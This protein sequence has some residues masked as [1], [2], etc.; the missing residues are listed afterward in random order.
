MA[1][2][3][4]QSVMLGCKKAEERLA[5]FLVATARRTGADLDFPIK[6]E[7]PMSRQDIADYVGLT[8]ETVSRTFTK[9]KREGLISLEGH[10]TVR[11]RRMRNL[12]ELAGDLELDA[13]W[14]SHQ[15]VAAQ[16]H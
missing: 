12:V 10:R 6:V 7:L 14:D 13:S 1:S 8:I 11:V 15:I 3:E 5:S 9:F 16:T 2:A 4:E